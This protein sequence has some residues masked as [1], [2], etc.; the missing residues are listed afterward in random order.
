MRTR[1]PASTPPLQL[2]ESHHSSLAAPLVH[3]IDA[4]VM[5][6]ASQLHEDP[7]EP[8]QRTA[9]YNITPANK[10]TINVHLRNS[11]PLPV[12]QSPSLCR[13]KVLN[14]KHVRILLDRTP[15]LWIYKNIIR[16]HLFRGNTMQIQYL[17][18]RARETTLW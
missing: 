9:Q 3:L 1:L 12:I 15:Q 18:N 7:K 16:L 17:D 5:T 8:T 4:L 2:W 14:K 10:F 11:R 13:F 6:K